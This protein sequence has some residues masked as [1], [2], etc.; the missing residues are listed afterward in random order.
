VGLKDILAPQGLFSDLGLKYI[1]P[2]AGH[3]RISVEK[4]LIQAKKYEG[5]VIVHCLTEKG[6]GFS[7][8][9]QDDEDRFHAVDRF[10]P[11]TGQGR[12]PTQE[13]T[14]TSVF[15]DEILTLAK[16]NPDLVAI[17]A[18]MVNPVGLGPMAAECPDRVFDVGIAEQ[19]GVTSAAGMAMAGLL[20]VVVVYATF[21][22]RGFDQVLMDVALHSM[23]VTFVLDRAGI[24][25]PEGASHHG[26]WDLSIL[27]GIPGLRVAVPRDEERLRLT[28]AQAIEERAHPTAVRFPKGGV[29]QP[30]PAVRHQGSVDILVDHVNPTV[31]LIGYGPMAHLAVEIAHDLADE[32]IA[33]LVIDPVWALPITDDT[34]DAVSTCEVVVTIEDGI[35]SGGIGSRIQLGLDDRGH[36]GSVIRCA[37]PDAFIP[38]GSRASILADLGFTRDRKSVV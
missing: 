29:P 20:P 17:S 14:W 21:L 33:A 32:G 37:I 10:N 31:G 23:P 35:D 19:H 13:T 6:H 30:L 11:T 22:N 1:G 12:T 36:P 2:V 7:A 27:G 25:G 4:A 28:L 16:K 5:P 15:A 34:I 38:Q 9:E 3:D 8:A 18:A 26:M 24:T